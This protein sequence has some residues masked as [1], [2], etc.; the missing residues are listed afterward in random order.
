MGV[1]RQV[2]VGDAYVRRYAYMQMHW[3]IQAYGHVHRSV[4][5]YVGVSSGNAKLLDFR[6]IF[7]Y[8]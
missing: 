3:C 2:C 1:V 8:F 7:A 4:C 5:R 6:C